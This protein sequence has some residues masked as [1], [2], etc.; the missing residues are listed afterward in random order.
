[1]NK[2]GSSWRRLYSTETPGDMACL[3]P[4]VGDSR[5]PFTTRTPKAMRISNARLWTKKEQ[6]E[7][8]VILQ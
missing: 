2:T 1:M 4:R 8:P 5:L 3:H 7:I 6:T